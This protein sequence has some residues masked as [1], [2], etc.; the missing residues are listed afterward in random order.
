MHGRAML[1][2][3]LLLFGV[4]APWS[5]PLALPDVAVQALMGDRVVIRWQGATHQLGVGDSVNGLSLLAADSDGAV[6]EYRGERFQR[7]LSNRVGGSYADPAPPEVRIRPDERGM[8]RTR[9]R[10]N[11]RS[12]ELIVDTGANL[13]AMGRGQAEALGVEV[14][15]GLRRRV[16]TA[17]GVTTGYEVRLDRVSVGGVEVRNVPAVILE[18]AGPP[19]P[20][21]GMSFLGRV[22]MRQEGGVL[23]LRGSQ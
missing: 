18:G 4:A 7:G 5:A 21:L 3:L 1:T 22:N 13:V 12:S 6:F 10:I 23:L 17:G 11:G 2:A 19:V 8:Y 16:E 20:L 15:G 14:D 9:G